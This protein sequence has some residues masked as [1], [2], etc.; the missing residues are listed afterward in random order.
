M[1]VLNP[2]SR[3]CEMTPKAQ[4]FGV[5]KTKQRMSPHEQSFMHN[6]MCTN[7]L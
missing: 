1:F 3:H 6:L 4:L 2:R 7:V 5:R